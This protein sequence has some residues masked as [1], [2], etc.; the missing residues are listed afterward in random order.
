MSEIVKLNNL[1]QQ[2]NQVFGFPNAARN[3]FDYSDGESAENYL[4]LVLTQAVDLSSR[5]QELQEKIVDWPSEY[6]LSSDRSNLLRS[7]DLSNVS[8]ALE[9]GS[10]C[11]AITRYLG[12]Q[13]IS[14][15]AIEG[16]GP[17]AQLGKL[18]CRDLDNVTVVNANYT[19]LE[20]PNKHY[21][22]IL[23]I[24]VIEYAKKFYPAALTDKE[25][26]IAILNQAREHINDH[27]LVMV[28]IENRLGLKYILGQHEDHYSKRYVGIHGYQNSPG[29]S[30]YSEQE[31]R[32]LI[33]LAGYKDCSFSYPFPDYKIPRLSMGEDYAKND[34]FAFNH[35]EGTFARDYTRPA[36]RSITES[37][38]WQAASQGK[39]LSTIANSFCL[40]AGKDKKSIEQTS[41]F[42]FCHMPGPA[43]KN[44]YAVTTHKP[45]NKNAVIK[46]SLDLLQEE[47][48][49]H[50]VQKLDNQPYLQGNLLST[51]WLRCILIYSRREE[52]DQLI[53][54]Y[55]YYLG[56]I[57]R[58]G[59][60]LT[61]D[62]LP[63]NIIVDDKNNYHSFDQEWEVD[64]QIDKEYLLFR[65]LLTFVVTNWVYIKDFL[66]WLELH[67]VRDFV[68]YG[69]RNHNIQLVQH[70]DGF[71]EMEN[72][73]Q[74]IITNQI[75]DRKVE[76]LLE[77]IFDFT[78]EERDIYAT[79]YWSTGKSEF[80][81]DN[82]VEIAFIP[83]PE[84]QEIEFELPKSVTSIDKIRFDPF[85]I[86]KTDKVGFF[87]ISKIIVFDSGK[88]DGAP[89]W[90]LSG[91]QEIASH[92]QAEGA[93]HEG[94]SGSSYW[95]SVTEFPKL[96]FEFDKKLTSDA[97]EN[98]SVR[99]EIRIAE[100]RE[101]ILAHQ[102]YL[103]EIRQS[104][105]LN[106]DL[107][108]TLHHLDSARREIVDIKA[109][110]PF[111]LG[112]KIFSMLKFFKK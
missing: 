64:W 57:E 2:K 107:K 51:E 1:E 12:E 43:R 11:G 16:S 102:R 48:D 85:D 87:S 112:M 101:Y 37:I 14:V 29:I 20:L 71:I 67:S 15:D 70:I 74:E 35:L 98:F 92:C 46:T 3:E 96:K 79:L 58:E 23:F 61:I 32:E 53:A 28:A 62:L 7:Y 76:H 73:F 18:R 66:G 89:V 22:L 110:R 60:K 10:G 77:T 25:A 63:I 50:V 30:T 38:A 52:F 69:F 108:N 84:I 68:D 59:K 34:P 78:S 97:I 6:H 4:N 45:K 104:D 44:K 80:S 56:T 103:T 33:D 8:C 39:F 24:G 90:Q 31:W 99:I 13:G 75:D 86:R 19:E 100:S 109:G 91:E 47:P 42:D 65:A 21:D 93:L 5:S 88:N 111:K 55:Y 72:R 54:D 95:M 9:L 83:D 40:I 82:S 26:T 81:E 41:G 106:K 49:P 36:R 105:R 27:G 94:F 17:R